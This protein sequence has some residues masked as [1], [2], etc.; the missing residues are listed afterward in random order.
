MNEPK[1]VRL[2]KAIPNVKSNKKKM[3]EIWVLYT[4]IQSILT[5]IMTIICTK[6]IILYYKKSKNEECCQQRHSIIIDIIV[7]FIPITR[8]IHS[9]IFAINP[10]SIMIFIIDYINGGIAVTILGKYAQHIFNLY[11]EIQFSRKTRGQKWKSIINDTPTKCWFILNRKKW[12]NKVFTNKVV[13]VYIITQIIIPL[14]FEIIG[15]HSVNNKNMNN[16]LHILSAVLK[17]P[18]FIPIII[19]VILYYRI[20]LFDDVFLIIKQ[21]KRN[22]YIIS[23]AYALYL[24]TYI[25]GKISF[26]FVSPTLIIICDILRDMAI[27]VPNPFFILN[28]TYYVIKNVIS[29]HSRKGVSPKPSSITVKTVLGN[30]D[31]TDAFMKHLSDGIA[32]CLYIPVPIYVCVIYPNRT[33]NGSTPVLFG[34]YSIQNIRQTN[35]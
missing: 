8:N 20:R 33:F 24:I 18:L 35:I 23:M 17:V 26:K 31:S 10:S 14:P 15:N 9:Y 32:L 25:F 30:D 29:E 4:I 12:G 13:N 19:M 22:G 7:L 6:Y 3:L 16:I 28:N 27:W 5:F 1:A 2:K 34:I 11:Y 21:C